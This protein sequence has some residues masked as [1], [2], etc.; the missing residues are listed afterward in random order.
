MANT[1]YLFSKRLLDLVSASVLL[2]LFLPIWAIIPILIKLDSPGPVFYKHRRVGRCG[3]P[4][5]MF[6]FRSM[7]NNAHDYLHHKNPALLEKFKANDWKLADDPRIPR[8]G[9]VLRSVTIDEFPQIINVLKGDMS[10]VGPRAYMIEE[11]NE[12]VKKYPETKPNIQAIYSIKPGITGPW[13]V[14]GRNE[15]PFT[16][17][18]ELDAKYAK[19][20]SLI[21]DL[22]IILK[23]PKAMFSKW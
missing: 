1:F 7:V 19:T 23:T 2:V 18:T 5:E 10:L 15:L 8:L 16:K 9:R 12:Q 14:S 17:R 20:Q 4:F 21:N 22:M 3:K 6:K 13:Q 11:I